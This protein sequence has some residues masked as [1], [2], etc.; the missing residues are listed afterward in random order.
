M[1]TATNVGINAVTGFAC[2]LAV[3]EMSADE[4][5][6]QADRLTRDAER[7][8]QREHA[9]EQIRAMREKASAMK[10]NAFSDAGI[11]A[12]S[13][14]AQGIGAEAGYDADVADASKTSDPEA[15][16]T[17]RI[18]AAV[19]KTDETA[20]HI[21]DLSFGSVETGLDATSTENAQAA[22]EAKQ[23]ADEANTTANRTL[24]L[25]DQKLAI[26]QEMLRSDSELMH[27]LI[28]RS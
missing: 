15:K 4:A 6:Y 13:A 14:V 18:C 2:E 1:G 11:L 21:N 23:R 7:A 20:I 27:T 3:L 5:S 10:L 12:T 22:E 28:S 8:A 26:I 24:S 25:N 9:A 19:S 16:L 17:D